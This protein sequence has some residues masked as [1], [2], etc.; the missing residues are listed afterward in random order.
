MPARSRRAGEAHRQDHELTTRRALCTLLAWPLKQM[1]ANAGA[2]RTGG[3]SCVRSG[4]WTQPEG[5]LG[6]TSSGG[7]KVSVGVGA[8]NGSLARSGAVSLEDASDDADVNT[9]AWAEGAVPSPAASRTRTANTRKTERSHRHEHHRRGL[10]IIRTKDIEHLLVDCR[11]VTRGK[12][13]S[14]TLH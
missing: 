13:R 11:C 14:N 2:T 5:Q 12:S 4:R 7:C 9:N 6:A 10:G 8:S 3:A 1:D